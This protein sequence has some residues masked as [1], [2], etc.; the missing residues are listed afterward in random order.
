M[1]RKTF[2]NT[3]SV[4]MS[5][6]AISITMGSL[7]YNAGNPFDDRPTPRRVYLTDAQLVNLSAAI[8]EHQAE[9]INEQPDAS[10]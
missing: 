10:K 2:M 5:L 4:I 1:D 8:K 7:M 9:K 6:A 3:V